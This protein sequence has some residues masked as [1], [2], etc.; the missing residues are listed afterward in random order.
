MYN[1]FNM[2]IGMVL[3][4]HPADV[5]QVESI[6]DAHDEAHY[7]VGSIIRQNEDR[8]ELHSASDK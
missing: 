2:G 8:V 4:V 7:R 5:E 3:M 6:L 1:I